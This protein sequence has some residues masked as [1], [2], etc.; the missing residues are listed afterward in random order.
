[1]LHFC[2]VGLN[3]VDLSARIFAWMK[4]AESCIQAMN[5]IF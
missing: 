1:M 2:S 5:Q 3:D 4:L